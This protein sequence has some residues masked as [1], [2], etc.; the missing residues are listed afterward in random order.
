MGCDPQRWWL[1]CLVRPSL[2]KPIPSLLLCPISGLHLLSPDPGPQCPDLSM[3][4][5]L[6]RTNAQHVAITQAPLWPNSISQVWLLLENMS[7]FSDRTGALPFYPFLQTSAQARLPSENAFFLFHTHIL[8]WLGFP[9]P[10]LALALPP[11]GGF[12]L[13]FFANTTSVIWREDRPTSKSV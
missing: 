12:C 1:T 11:V 10:R 4:P 5:A 7:P 9:P 2:G 13:L 3:S 6:L 8:F